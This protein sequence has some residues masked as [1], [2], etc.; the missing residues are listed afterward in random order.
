MPPVPRIVDR[1]RE[2]G[3]PS[4]LSVVIRAITQMFSEVGDATP[5]LVGEH[6]A[7]AP[8]GVG[9]PP[10]VILVPEPGGGACKLAGQYETGRVAK[11]VHACDVIVRAAESGDDIDRLAAVYDLSDRVA[12]CV[13]RAGAGKVEFGEPI[14]TYPSPTTTDAFGA[15]L[16]WSFTYD[17]DISHD[18]AIMALPGAAADTTPARPYEVPGQTGT[19]DTLD[20]TAV[21]ATEQ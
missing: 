18:R 11:H 6:Y 16:S 17:R 3:A 15:G 8:R 2:H 9:S 1:G 4:D 12:T 21:D 13:R 20:G 19:L 14:G 10:L 5:I 7:I